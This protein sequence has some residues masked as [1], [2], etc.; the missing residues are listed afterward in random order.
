MVIV[1]GWNEL[2]IASFSHRSM[3]VKDGIVLATGLVVS[4]SMVFPRGSFVVD[5]GRMFQLRFNDIYLMCEYFKLV[6]ISRIFLLI[7]LFCPLLFHFLSF[8]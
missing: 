5:C 3:G 7:I 2:L 6:Y 8:F 1:A 4:F